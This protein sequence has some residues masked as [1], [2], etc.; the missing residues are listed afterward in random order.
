MG[1][2]IPPGGNMENTPELSGI[3][4]SEW[5]AGK[6]R[7]HIAEIAWNTRMHVSD[8]NSASSRHS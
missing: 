4:F 2:V 6:N 7:I 1:I 8:Q 3:P 5:M